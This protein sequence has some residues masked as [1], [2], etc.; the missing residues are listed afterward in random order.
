MRHESLIRT[1]KV[2]SWI[3]AIIGI[4]IAFVLL[5][6]S[7]A[8]FI[9]GGKA[10]VLVFFYAFSIGLFSCFLAAIGLALAALVENTEPAAISED[11]AF[12]NSTTY[13]TYAGTYDKKELTQTRTKPNVYINVFGGK[14]RKKCPV[15][16]QMIDIEILKCHFCGNEFAP[17]EIALLVE[18]FNKQ[19][20][21]LLI[22]KENRICP[23]CKQEGVLSD[24]M[25][26]DASPG[27]YCRHCD[28]YFDYDRPDRDQA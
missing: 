2:L 8:I 23:Y 28:K 24:V 14:R 9:S 4:F 6:T 10:G 11:N 17:E 26:R 5:C 18:E 19:R 13:K 12:S 15:C 25:L 1:L 27:F 16:A 21:E 7:M 20:E 22:Q 3:I